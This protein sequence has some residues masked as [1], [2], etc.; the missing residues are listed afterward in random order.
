MD[1]AG[2]DQFA[3]PRY[4]SSK[5]KVSLMSSFRI[6]QVLLLILRR[7]QHAEERSSAKTPPAGLDSDIADFLCRSLHNNSAH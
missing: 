2:P 1:V 7:A 3:G 6:D 5:F 4:W